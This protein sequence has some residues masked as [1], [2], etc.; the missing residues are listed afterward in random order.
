MRS[1]IFAGE[2]IRP[3]VGG[4][5]HVNRRLAVGAHFPLADDR[6]EIILPVTAVEPKETALVNIDYSS[7]SA[8]ESVVALD[9]KLRSVVNADIALKD[10][11]VCVY[12]VVELSFFDMQLFR[13]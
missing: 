13:V 11:T 6:R 3:A 7:V 12:R 4:K 1:R 2:H 5:I 9:V 10:S 8:I